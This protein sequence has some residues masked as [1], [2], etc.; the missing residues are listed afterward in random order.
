MEVDK[1]GAIRFIKREI[2]EW[3]S[4]QKE[5]KI[6]LKQHNPAEELNIHSGKELMKTRQRNVRM[7]RYKLAFLHCICEQLI[8]GSPANINH[9]GIIGYRRSI[10]QMYNKEI[11]KYT[12]YI[13]DCLWREYNV[14]LE[15]PTR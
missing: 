7:N 4:L 2:A 12:R 11:I 1:R 8:S 3:S 5:C 6:N 14:G 10:I 9:W 13:I 15:Q